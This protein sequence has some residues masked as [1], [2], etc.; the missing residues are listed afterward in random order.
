MKRCS[1]LG[2]A[3]ALA[4]RGTFT[5]LL[6]LA[7]IKRRRM[8][9]CHAC[10]FERHIGAML[11][12]IQ[13]SFEGCQKAFSRLENLKIHLRSHT[14]E[15]PYVCQHPGCQKA[16]SNSSDRA[17]HQRTHIDMKP[18]A[19]QIQGC[20]KRYTD[21][22][23]LRKH[24]KSHSLKEQQARKKLRR[25]TDLS[26]DGLTECLT[27]QPLQHSLVP[28]D[29]IETKHQ[30]PIDDLYTVF[31]LNQSAMQIPA[32]PQTLQTHMQLPSLQGNNRL[33]VPVSHQVSPGPSALLSSHHSLDTHKLPRYPSHPRTSHPDSF[34]ADAQ[35]VFSYGDPP[36]AAEHIAPCSMM[37]MPMF[38][39]NL[40]SSD[41]LHTTLSG[42]AAVFDCQTGPEEFLGEQG[43]SEDNY[44]HIRSVERSPSRISCVFT[45]G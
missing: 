43:P 38:E 5:R 34:S 4:C 31:T 11:P 15:K 24:V 29:L 39:D 42:T 18:Y 19:C 32:G 1:C 27:V 28:L 6:A 2:D 10:D 17:K 7:A 16:F 13:G 23:S 26:Q 35:T 14:G 20:A 40:G 30:S 3:K 9:C 12:S 37:Q 21:P 8:A 45:E 25:S 41:L 36:Q 22:S 44:L 33:R